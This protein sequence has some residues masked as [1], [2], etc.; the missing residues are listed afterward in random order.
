MTLF[1]AIIP[2][3]KDTQKYQN[4]QNI[5]IYVGD[6]YRNLRIS[7]LF[8]THY[9]KRLKLV[10]IQRKYL[11]TNACIFVLITTEVTQIVAVDICLL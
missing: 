3:Q 6:N 10:L 9:S 4:T 5:D 7:S 1:Y 11:Q 8:I 2:I